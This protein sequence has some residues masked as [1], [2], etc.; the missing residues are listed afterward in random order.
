MTAVM[1]SSHFREDRQEG[2]GNEH[3]RES[4]FELRSVWEQ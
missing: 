3:W 4:F 2:G 1:V